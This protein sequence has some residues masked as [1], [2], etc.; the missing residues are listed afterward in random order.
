MPP[1]GGCANDKV[2]PISSARSRMLRRPTPPLTRPGLLGVCIPTPSSE[3]ASSHVRIPTRSIRSEIEAAW[4]WRTPDLPPA[5]V[6]PCIKAGTS[7]KGACPKCGKPWGRKI[8]PTGHVNKR[9]AAHVPNNAPTKTDSSGWAPT[10]KANGQWFPA[11]TCDAGDP[12]PCVVLDPFAGAGTVALVADRL[13]R[14]SIGIELNAEYVKMAVQRLRDDGGMLID[15][16]V[17]HKEEP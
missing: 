15:V 13:G 9:E 5:L 3:S 7:E 4:A 10:K 12:V 2:A 11:C 16:R 17:E 1:E 8:A 6:E 14:D